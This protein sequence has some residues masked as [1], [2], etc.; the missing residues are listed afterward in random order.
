MFWTDYYLWI[1]K[2]FDFVNCIYIICVFASQFQGFERKKNNMRNETF[3]LKL[4]AWNVRAMCVCVYMRFVCW[5][6]E[7][8]REPILVL[9]PVFSIILIDDEY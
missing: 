3:N 1:I 7:L 2:C 8:A 5:T 4:R 9:F 6:M